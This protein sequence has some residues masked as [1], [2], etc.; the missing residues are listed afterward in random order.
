MRDRNGNYQKSFLAIWDKNGNY[1][2]AFPLFRTGT[3]NPRKSSCCLA[4]GIQGLPV[5]KYTGMEI[6]AHACLDFA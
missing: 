3:G 1:Q 4:M 6:P 5:G 2:K